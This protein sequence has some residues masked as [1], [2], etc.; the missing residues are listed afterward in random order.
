MRI[1]IT[2]ATGNVGTAL[3]RHLAS[4]G[5]HQL[6]GLARRIPD[7]PSVGGR[8]VAW[9]SV[10]LTADEDPL[11]GIVAG[12]DAVVHLA[13]GFQPSHDLDYLE[14][15]GVGGTRRV[16][17]A[18]RAAG[19]P[20][21]VHQSSLGAYSPRSD[22]RPVDESYPTG[23]VPTSPYSR[24]KVAAERLLDEAETEDGAGDLTITRM[25]PGVIGQRSAGSAL[26]RYGVPGLVP[27]WVL[28]RLPV[29]P[30]DRGLRIAFVH[31][32]DV[33]DAIGRVLDQRV[34]GAFNLATSSPLSAADIANTFG[35]RLVHVPS[36][37]LRAGVD[38]SWRL[39]LQQIDAGWLD[40]GFA[41]PHLDS[42]RARTE[43]GWEPAHSA[44]ETFAE[45]LDGMREGASGPTAVLRP[46]S[47]A[48]TLGDAVRRGP[49]GQRRTP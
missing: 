27:S 30:L 2:G 41:L 43:L 26:M 36:A 20:H 28:G 18:V 11:P 24:H 37:V 10:D 12:A 31:A 15:L 39:H 48:Q 8:E 3:L 9:H 44:I 45:V 32:D 5:D 16:L 22:D 38:V 40:M 46:R 42:T 4:T 21:L 47:L 1:V 13:W 33:A 35:A 49:V 34:G 7:T 14:R 29:L 25:R 19:V 6:V 23:G 17:D